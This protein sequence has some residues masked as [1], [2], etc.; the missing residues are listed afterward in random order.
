MKPLDYMELV[1][2]KLI[3]I[4]QSSG[5][6][7]NPTPNT[8]GLGGKIDIAKNT[9]SVV[10]FSVL[11][12]REC[13]RIKDLIVYGVKREIIIKGSLYNIS[14]LESLTVYTGRLMGYITIIP[15]SNLETS[16][17]D[18]SDSEI[19]SKISTFLEELILP[20]ATQKA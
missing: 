2:D 5:L 9:L 19:E 14:E 13:N 20:Q 6:K 11:S 4:A 1:K 18:N 8:L 12:L 3:K 10:H 7:I 17:H 16:L 15:H